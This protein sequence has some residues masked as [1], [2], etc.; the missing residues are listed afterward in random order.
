[1]G[2]VGIFSIWLS[3]KVG[4]LLW[5]VL[6]YIVNLTRILANVPGADGEF[7]VSWPMLIGIYMILI[8]I[9]LIMGKR[10]HLVEKN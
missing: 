2:T 4:L 8:E 10:K 5:W 9:L 7:F 6:G 3:Q 1:V